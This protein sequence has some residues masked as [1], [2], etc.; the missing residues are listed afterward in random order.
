MDLATLEH[1]H[2][3]FTAS[4]K[5]CS[6]IR[7]PLSTPQCVKLVLCMKSCYD[8]RTITVNGVSRVK[9]FC[10]F[11]SALILHVAGVGLNVMFD[12][13]VNFNGP[14]NPCYSE[15]FCHVLKCLWQVLSSTR[16]VFSEAHTCGVDFSQQQSHRN[17]FTLFLVVAEKKVN[18]MPSGANL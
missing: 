4:E 13:P 2:I 18:K 5:P 11:S 3:C 8:V 7:F 9:T 16:G 1:T 12:I 10:H 14:I 17:C 15:F 6:F